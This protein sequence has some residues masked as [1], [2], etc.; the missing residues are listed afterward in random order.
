[1]EN[2]PVRTVL[3]GLVYFGGSRMFWLIFVLSLTRARGAEFGL[4]C[5]YMREK[6]KRG[7]ASRKDLAERAAAQ[8]AAGASNYNGDVSDGKESS[9]SPT[10]DEKADGFVENT[11][12]N[13]MSSSGLATVHD[14]HLRGEIGIDAEFRH[15]QPAPT[16]GQ[17]G[18]LSG[19]SHMLPP[20][21]IDQGTIHDDRSMSISSYGGL[22]TS[23][24]RQSLSSDDLMGGSQ[25][26]GH[27][28]QNNMHGYSELSFGILGQ[29]STDFGN[30]SGFRLSNSPLGA[31]A[32]LTS[33]TSSGWG[34]PISSPP[35]Q[36]QTQMQHDFRQSRLRYPVLEPLVPHIANIIPIYLACDLIDLYFASS[37]SAGIH[38]MSPYILGS[39]FRKR[40]FLHPTRPRKCR[41]A[42]LASMLWVAAQTS[43]AP[44]LTSVPSARGKIC[45]KLLDLTVA[46]LKPLIHS[47]SIYADSNA[48]QTGAAVSLGG[49]G[50]ALPGSM[51]VEAELNGNS[52]S[53]GSS[54]HLDDVVTYIHLA[55][56]VSASEYKG[57]SLRWWNVAW[58]M[59]RELKLG[60][61]LP[62]SE[63]RPSFEQ[64]KME[65]NG[66]DEHDILRNSPGFVTE[67]EREE[68]RRIWWLVYTV[69]RHL[70][71]CYNR[72]LFLLD[73]ECEGLRQP[74]DDAAWQTG[75]F[76]NYPADSNI[77][78]I[79]P[80]NEETL[81]GPQFRCR[82]YSVFGYFLPLMTILGEIVDLHHARNH[83]R[84]GSTFR[85]SREWSNQVSEVRRHLRS[86]EG[87]LNLF[88]TQSSLAQNNGDHRD[89]NSILESHNGT[90]RALELNSSPSAQSVH[91]TASSRV[92]KAEVQTRTVL[93]YGTHVM[94]VLHILLEGKWDP[95][96]LLD[97]DDL[98]ISSP[99][100]VTAS[101][102]AVAAAEAI[103]QILEY[104][105]GLEFM[106]FFFGVYLLQGSFLLLLIADKLQVEASPNV[107]RACETIVRAHEACVV[108]LSTEYQ[109]KFSR[110]MRGALALV[111]GRVPEDLG[112]QLQR[113]RE[114]LGL[115][116]WTGDGTG[117]A[118]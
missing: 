22:S 56:V 87:S 30:S 115:Y 112:E 99:D 65:T 31:Y 48:G 50:V 74:L 103:N 114:L 88:E 72:P 80:E 73:I 100:F 102:H 45:Q 23:Y 20:I 106:P 33:T 101:A 58:S 40:A 37:S 41:P 16:P 27:P 6:K 19:Q 110:V 109:R 84:F 59:A 85:A 14:N 38:P 10:T 49:L 26:Y 63:P 92:T 108:T 28:H 21:Q 61:E 94:H 13:S 2:I 97:D 17:F 32:G 47:S 39:V 43:E 53:F 64:S 71:L 77:L 1:M 96:N 67:E 34:M 78:G 107:V 52:G 42:L 111:R 3:V 44:L 81:C 51:S 5:E 118:L 66:L 82:G 90:Q 4:G 116:R 105:P 75:D 62:P 36:F 24:D 91:T 70:A 76:K 89:M 95:V 35:D 12:S 46:L 57:A 83:P 98:W 113:R 60:R 104:D 55:T 8:A 79:L 18:E 93:A 9:N 25:A 69:D 29:V 11:R 86:Y 68:R 54:G 7:K 15:E 117:L